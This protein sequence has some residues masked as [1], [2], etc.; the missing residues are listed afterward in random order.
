MIRKPYKEIVVDEMNSIK[1]YGNNH[2]IETYYAVPEWNEEGEEELAFKYKDNEYFL[3]EFMNIHNKIYNPN[4]P[5]WMLE[6]DGY[7][8]D[9]FFSGILIK[10]ID[11]GEA[12]KAYTYIS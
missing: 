10:L 8:S 2:E 11:N 6:F 9:S 7:K 12:V 4:P 5:E 3:S 1:I